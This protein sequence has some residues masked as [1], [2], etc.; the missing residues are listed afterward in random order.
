MPPR[1]C[2]ALT[3]PQIAFLHDPYLVRIAPGASTRN[4]TGTKDLDLG[5][6]LKVCHKVGLSTEATSPSD[7][8]PRRRTDSAAPAPP[9][10]I[11]LGATA[12]I[13]LLMG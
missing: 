10:M 8:P 5:S 7:G 1:R 12:P 6:E 13:T 9:L 4:I 2:S 11:V 3:L